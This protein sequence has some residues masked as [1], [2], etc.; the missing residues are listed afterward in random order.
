M[1]DEEL[2]RKFSLTKS[3]FSRYA[4]RDWIKLLAGQEHRKQRKIPT[5]W[6]NLAQILSA[7]PVFMD[8]ARKARVLPKV[9]QV[10]RSSQ[11]STLKRD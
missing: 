1:T 5:L 11:S 2:A 6:H 3:S 9:E 8:A 4:G 7:N 10:I